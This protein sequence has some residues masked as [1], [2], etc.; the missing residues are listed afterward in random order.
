MRI[1]E[2]AIIGPHQ[3]EKRAFIHSIADSVEVE[4]EK[5]TFG[6]LVVNNQLVLH[7]YGFA[8]DEQG[9]SV[10]W[11]LISNKLLGFVV[12]FR[13]GDA[14]SFRKVQKLVDYLT[15]QYS[16]TVIVAGHTEGKVPHLPAAFHFGIPIDK[17]GAFIFCNVKEAVSVR[18]VLLALIDQIID[19]M[20]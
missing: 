1:G 19:Q 2:I 17:R 3:E 7:L 15:E 18:K 12:L 10:S 14:D 16:A 4:N 13:W 11:D 20:D 5:L 8:V 6:R 9:Q